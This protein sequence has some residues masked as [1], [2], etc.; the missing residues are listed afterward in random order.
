MKSTIRIIISVLPFLFATVS[1][2]DVF[3]DFNT[4]LDGWTAVTS[5]GTPLTL[6]FDSIDG[7]PGG[8][9]TTGLPI[10]GD[11]YWMVAPAAYL[12]DWST[13]DGI[14]T[15]SWDRIG[16]AGY[17][18]GTPDS[19]LRSSVI[20]SGPGGSATY[21]ADGLLTT[22]WKTFS[23]PIDA[24]NW[25]IDSGSWSSILQNVTSLKILISDGQ[26]LKA[27]PQFII[28]GQTGIGN[29]HYAPV[30]GMDNINLDPKPDP[31]PEP[32]SIVLLCTG[33]IGLLACAWRK[34][35]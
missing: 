17:L 23:A 24:T 3:S 34:R 30:T 18:C 12:G 31:V 29:I 35:K 9:V 22:S 13:Y 25:I 10:L 7:N 32:G 21:T 33:V 19:E 14:G 1:N 6:L 4:G 5:N 16:S 8:C 2:A 15:L 11:S 26:E 27:Y 28:F 20:I